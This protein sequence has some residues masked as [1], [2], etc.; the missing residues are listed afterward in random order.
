MIEFQSPGSFAKAI[1]R[2]ASDLLAQMAGGR[3]AN[4]RQWL[5]SLFFLGLLLGAYGALLTAPATIA[6]LVIAAVCGA[7]GY[8]V[9]AAFCHDAS[10]GSLHRRGWINQLAVW[11]GFA[12]M[13]IHGPLWRYRHLKKHHPFPNVEGTDVDADGSTLIRLS[14]HKPWRPLH[15]WQPFYAPVLYALVLVHLAWV[16]DFQHWRNAAREAPARFRGLRMALSF[17]GV[18]MVHLLIALVLP[19]LILQPPLWAL[20][21]GYLIAAS[22]ASLLFVMINVGSHIT[23]VA[24]FP[25]PGV[26]GR[27]AQDWA[28]HQVATAIDW[29]P[30]NRL[31]I[32]LT[33][34]AN[35]HAAHHLFPAVAHCHN[36]DL[37]KIVAKQAAA[38]GLTHNVL[39]FRGMLAAHWRHLRR[40]A[41]AEPNDRV[42]TA[43]GAG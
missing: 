43:S 23:D 27:L 25:K 39:G 20:L 34:G 3:F 6:S 38:H 22:T 37:A 11:L 29:S 35:A 42:P 19:W 32:V 26:Y 2:D 33:G 30:T 24:T 15:R 36:G 9:I 8:V 1:R 5:W 4:Q 21:L 13:G 10:H 16:E 40:L 31:A 18:K 14:P 7:L 28:S 41:R 17:I 12:L